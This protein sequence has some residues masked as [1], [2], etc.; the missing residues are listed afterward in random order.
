M[1][2]HRLIVPYS[3]YQSNPSTWGVTAV[4]DEAPCTSSRRD[5][6]K[7]RGEDGR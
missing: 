7:D 2:T 6:T 1:L 5:S 3:S 4:E